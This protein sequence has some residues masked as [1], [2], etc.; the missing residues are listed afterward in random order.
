MP[1]DNTKWRD[2]ADR[3]LTITEQARRAQLIRVTIELV[4]QHGYPGTSLA[5]IAEAADL[6]KAAVLYHFP[7][8]D[9]VVRAAYATVLEGL[10]EHVSAAV[11]PLSGAAAL[12]AYIRSLVGYLVEHPAYARVIVAAIAED[13][14]VTDRPNAPSRWQ[15]VGLL[16]EAASA[17][18]DHRVGPDPRITAVIINGAIDAIVSEYLDD[19]RFDTTRAVDELVDLLTRALGR[20]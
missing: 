18:G 4:A 10:T 13:E 6:S 11:E 3:S 15:T 7:S 14:E 19:P 8:K 5:R 20:S 17:A 12:E 9:A 16:V 1:L 2:R